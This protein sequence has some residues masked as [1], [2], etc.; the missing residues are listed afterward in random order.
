MLEGFMTGRINGGR[1]RVHDLELTRKTIHRRK[2]MTLTPQ[3]ANVFI[4]RVFLSYGMDPTLWTDPSGWRHI[5]IGLAEGYAGIVEWQPDDPYLVVLAPLFDLPAH[6][7]GPGEFFY[8]LL[9]LNYQSTLSAHFSIHENTVYLGVNRPIRGLDEV[10]VEE[11]IRTVMALADSY[12]ERLKEIMHLIPPWMPQLPDIRMRP[13][14]AQ[15]IGSLLAACD[16]HGQQIFRLMMEAWEGIGHSVLAKTTGIGLKFNSRGEAIPLAALHP[17]FAE[18]RQEVILLWQGLRRKYGFPPSAVDSFQAAVF[19]VHDLRAIESMA[20]IEVTKAFDQESGRALLKA[21]Q[22]FVC[23][24]AGLEAESHIAGTNQGLPQKEL[25]ADEKALARIREILQAGEAHSTT[26]CAIDPEV[27]E[28]K[29]G[30]GMSSKRP[31]LSEAS[32]ARAPAWKIRE[33]HSSFQSCGPIGV[34]G[35]QRAQHRTR[36]ESGM[37]RICIPCL[38][39]RRGRTLSAGHLDPPG[40]HSGEPGYPNHFGRILPREACS[41]PPSGDA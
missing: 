11:A 6:S 33:A 5:M 32:D 41:Y 20:H 3:D 4:D 21:M 7:N 22:D 35:K 24:L 38:C 40:L 8:V 15:M 39:C 13:Q 10:E 30:S 16:P 19:R 27:G 9:E 12:D 18:R 17:G 36:L 1:N 28:C 25:Q 23:T 26:L 34:R 31:H 37:W 29:W 2:P 14:E